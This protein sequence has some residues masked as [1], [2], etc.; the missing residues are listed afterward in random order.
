MTTIAGGLI[1]NASIIGFGNSATNIPIVNG[2][3]DLTGSILAPVI[4]FAFS[5]P[6]DGTITSL[7]AYFSNDVSLDLIGS[8]ITIT[9][10][11][12]ISTTPNNIF[13]S[14]GASVALQPPL[15]GIISLGDISSGIASGLS[16]PVSAGDRLLLVFST[17]AQGV[18]LIN[19]VIGYA[20]AGVAI[21]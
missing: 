5:V 12:Y 20:S 17:V 19:T 2:T 13:H 6:R 8:S 21:D 4:N 1:G 18:S 10:E 14:T 15:S 3:I 16:I 9:A 11:L 7:A